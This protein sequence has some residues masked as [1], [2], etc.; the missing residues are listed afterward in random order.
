MS[1][2]EEQLK[3]LEDVLDRRVAIRAME[4]LRKAVTQ[5]P[6]V[7]SSISDV[8][9]GLDANVFLKLS[10]HKNRADVVDYFA[11]RHKAPLVLPGQVIQE[12]WNNQFAVIHSVAVQF[13]KNF[14]ALGA[15]AQKIDSTYGEFAEKATALLQDLGS[16][17]GYIRDKATVTNLTSICEMLSSVARVE[18]VSR[19]RFHELAVHRKRTRT[20]PGFKDD[21]DG[22][23]FVW[24]DVLAGLLIEKEAGRTFDRV[25]MVTDDKKIDWS[26]AGVAHPIL[27]AEVEALTGASF[28]VCSFDALIG[29]VKAEIGASGVTEAASGTGGHVDGEAERIPAPPNA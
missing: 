2:S 10:G 3:R 9:I 8:A 19:L 15:E 29:M 11:S 21:G 17:Y 7:L 22:D 13:K 24:L 16:Q 14:D 23:F 20:P 12:F 26:I 1:A 4:C 25:V 18:Y 5:K 6:G 27:C 28:E